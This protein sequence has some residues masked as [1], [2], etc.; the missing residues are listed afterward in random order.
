MAITRGQKSTQND[1]NA[2]SNPTSWST[3]PTTGQKVI[4]W[5]WQ[6]GGEAA[7]TSVADNGSP[8]RT[9][10]LAASKVDATNTQAIRIYYADDVRPSGTYTVTVTWAASK[11]ASVGGL[12]YDGVATGG[13]TATNSAGPT[14]SASVSSG[15]VSS[16]AN[17]LY[18]AGFADNSNGSDT[19]TP[20]GG[21][22]DQHALDD[23][24][25][26]TS[27]AGSDLINATGSQTATWSISIS[28]IWDAAIGVWPEQVA[29]A[30]GRPAVHYGYASN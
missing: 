14:T 1:A 22:T 7:P 6:G 19:V 4:V 8:S 24:T 26:F 3:A 18:V 30:G 15:A 2:S 21:F 29:A 10:T 11:F 16:G 20:G 25:F 27:G 13:P 17:S 28:R 23:G 12:A 9:F 5:V